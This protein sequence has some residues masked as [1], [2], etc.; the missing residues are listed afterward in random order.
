MS[1]AKT[2]VAR[3]VAVIGSGSW[4][5][6]VTGLLAPHV[7][8]VSLWSFEP[9]VVRQINASRHNPHQLTKYEVDPCVCATS[10]LSEATDDADAILLVVPSAFLRGVCEQLVGCVDPTT[11][12]LVLTKGV[13]RTTGCLMVDVVAQTLGFAERIAVLSGPN[14]AEEISEGT[15]SAA[16]VAAHDE[17]IARYFQQMVVSTTFRAYVSDDVCGVEVCAAVKN[18]IALACGVASAMGAGDNT[19]AALMT[20]GLAEMNRIAVSLGADPLTCMGLAGMGDLV[21][22]CT[23]HHSRN[24]TFGEAYVA[25]ESL[26]QYQARTGMV[27]EGAEAAASIHELAR[28]KHVDA[29]ITNA[30]YQI[31]YEDCDLGD[32]MGMLLGRHPRDEFYGVVP[33]ARSGEEEEE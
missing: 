7:E 14:H 17:R 24:R 19:L 18:V 15:I 28:E 26:A 31:L 1:A 11:P 4:G 20:R 12:I 27:V 23:S 16:V 10:S 22:T 3:K 2:L 6:A 9:E 30:V 21:V 33:G 29:P 25:G 8:L 13:E 32:A 5:T